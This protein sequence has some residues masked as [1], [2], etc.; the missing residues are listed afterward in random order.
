MTSNTNKK[1]QVK[2]RETTGEKKS[3]NFCFFNGTSS[4]FW[5]RDSY[6]YFALALKI[7][8]LTLAIL[9]LLFHPEK[10]KNLGL[11]KYCF[12]QEGCPNYLIQI[13]LLSLSLC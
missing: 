13:S 11:S 4:A 8:E 5:T 9:L 10:K 3:F 2:L 6:F 12:L 7:L 1:H